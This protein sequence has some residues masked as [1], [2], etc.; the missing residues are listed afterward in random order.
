MSDIYYS[1][2][3]FGLTAIGQV[4]FS[5]GNYC[6]DYTAVWQTDDGAFVYADDY[7]C[8]CPSPFES[9][10]VNDLLPVTSLTEFGAYLESRQDS[11]EDRSSDI[12]DL[13]ERMHKAGAR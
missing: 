7:G 1:P 2:E 10:S 8:S 3:K 5:D 6:F 12:A 4:D 11:S 9:T 13:L